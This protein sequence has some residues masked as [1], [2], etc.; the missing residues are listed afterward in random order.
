MGVTWTVPQSLP[1]G[2]AFRY[3]SLPL[4]IKPLMS[5]VWTS[6]L[7][8]FAFLRKLW[9][10]RHRSLTSQRHIE[11]KVGD[12]F[13]PVRSGT[14]LCRTR[15][16][17]CTNAEFKT[18]LLGCVKTTNRLLKLSKCSRSA[19]LTMRLA[20]HAI[21]CCCLIAAV[22][23][24]PVDD[25]AGDASLKKRWESDLSPRTPAAPWC[26]P[27]TWLQDP[28]VPAEPREDG[29]GP[30]RVQ[31]QPERVWRSRGPAGGEGE[32]S[33]TSV[34]VSTDLTVRGWLTFQDC[35]DSHDLFSPSS[36]LNIRPRRAA[37][38]AGCF[39]FA[40]VYHNLLH[41]LEHFSSKQKVKTAPEK[42]MR[43][44]GYGRRRRRSLEDGAP[45]ALQTD[46]RD[47]GEALPVCGYDICTVA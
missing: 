38:A 26:S 4:S 11:A 27:L 2:L 9:R 7:K 17:K 1:L 12:F 40:C 8:P 18:S 44:S 30:L 46:E 42:R 15:V 10:E 37:K 39:L 20:L 5:A 36:G 47:S 13:H 3:S 32:D 28:S 34:Q 41:R 33:L 16:W 24:V 6:A 14:D 35:A 19:A 31:V 22:L 45:A 21:I 25:A 29:A 23:P 43:P